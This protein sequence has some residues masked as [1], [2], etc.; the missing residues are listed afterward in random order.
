MN[1]RDYINFLDELVTKQPELL[2][3]DVIYV[4]DDEGNSYEH[5]GFTP[6]IMYREKNTSDYY[7]GKDEFDDDSE[8]ETVVVIN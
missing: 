4:S 5:V 1:L 3:C 8:I 7:S 6:S 2:D